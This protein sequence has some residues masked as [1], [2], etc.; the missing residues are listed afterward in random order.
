MAL[1][2]YIILWSKQKCVT[3]NIIKS[4]TSVCSCFV[5]ILMFYIF[6]TILNECGYCM[7]G[8]FLNHVVLH[9]SKNYHQ[10]HVTEPRRLRKDVAVTWGAVMVRF[11]EVSNLCAGRRVRKHRQTWPFSTLQKLGWAEW[12]KKLTSMR[13]LWYWIERQVFPTDDNRCQQSRGHAAQFCYRFALIY[14]GWTVLLCDGKF[15]FCCGIAV[16]YKCVT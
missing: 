15:Y 1:L 6:S 12:A 16:N 13:E 11:H 7:A 2:F 9:S 10:E 14:R 5:I 4:L 3:G 8:G